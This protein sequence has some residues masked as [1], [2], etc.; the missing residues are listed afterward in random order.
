MKKYYVEAI[1]NTYFE[2]LAYF[3]TDSPKTAI[4]KWIQYNKKYPTCVAIFCSSVKDCMAI[5]K[6]FYINGYEVYKPKMEE[7]PRGFYYNFFYLYNGSKSMLDL[8]NNGK[9]RFQDGMY[10]QVGYFGFG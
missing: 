1:E 10:D 6:E 5:Y 9:F 2:R 8:Y 4:N 3:E 7:N